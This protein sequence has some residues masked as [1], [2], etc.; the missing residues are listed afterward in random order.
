MRETA[1]DK[2]VSRYLKNISY[3]YTLEDAQKFIKSGEYENFRS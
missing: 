1:N 3:P 2:D